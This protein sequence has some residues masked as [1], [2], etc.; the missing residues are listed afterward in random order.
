MRREEEI[1]SIISFVDENRESTA[2]KIVCGKILGEKDRKIDDGMVRE[3][4]S[5]L[6]RTKGDIIDDCYHI[7][8]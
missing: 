8:S 6:P 1:A 2:S 5:R 3:L 7:I 4:H